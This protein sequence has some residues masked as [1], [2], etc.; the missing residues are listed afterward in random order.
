[1]FQDHKIVTLS[2]DREEIL[3]KLCNGNDTVN[4]EKSSTRCGGYDYYFLNLLKKEGEGKDDLLLE[5]A[6]IRRMKKYDGNQ[7]V[8][9]EDLHVNRQES[10]IRDDDY[11]LSGNKSLRKLLY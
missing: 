9:K 6:R 10:S 3:Q 8:K 1:M 5:K 7:N 4:N 11:L 2:Q